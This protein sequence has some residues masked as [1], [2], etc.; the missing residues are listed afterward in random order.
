MNEHNLSYWFRQSAPYIHAFRKKTFVVHLQGE[1]F[2]S[3]LITPLLQDLALLNSLRINVVVVFGARTQI[4]QQLKALGYQSEFSNGLRITAAEH[5]AAI[6]AAVGQVRSQVE[7]VLSMGLV[8]TPMHGANIRLISGNFVVGK[9]VGVRGGIDYGH[10]GLVRSVDVDAINAQLEQGNLIVIPPVGYSPSGERFNL[11]SVVVATE[12]AKA[13]KA[14]KLIMLTDDELSDLPR[15]VPPSSV[16]SY[17]NRFNEHQSYL[18]SMLLAAAEVTCDTGV[19]RSHIINASTD[20]ALLNELFSRDGVGVLITHEVYDSIRQATSDDLA[21]IINLISPLQEAGILVKREPDQVER[22]LGDYHVVSRDGTIVACMA[23]HPYGDSAE[24]ACVAVH[25]E[26]RRAKLADKLLLSMD[27][28][29]KE[30]GI[31]T[32]FALTTQTAHWFVE[33]GFQ[34]QPLSALPK[35]RAQTHDNRRGSK[36]LMKTVK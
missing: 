30:T 6:D 2:L 17:T 22:N 29:A 16:A 12:V 1:L 23:L 13:L 28:I 27:T 11:G 35:V 36:L 24:I 7:S 20:G 18:A 8:N 9:P 5:M 15:E 32:L 25:P 14:E 21:G 33:R 31:K 34:E 10:T 19:A 26:Y 3:P 4:D